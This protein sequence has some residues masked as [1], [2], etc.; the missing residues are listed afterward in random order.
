MTTDELNTLQR[1]TPVYLPTD[2]AHVMTWLFD[3]R[4]GTT[5][6][7]TFTYPP[8]AD[9]VV[10]NKRP[11]YFHALDLLG[12]TLDEQAA[13]LAVAESLEERKQWIYKTKLVQV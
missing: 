8:D 10:S 11:V 12:A 7:Y 3:A 1:G 9:G 6:Y 13:W 2:T 4:I 5:N